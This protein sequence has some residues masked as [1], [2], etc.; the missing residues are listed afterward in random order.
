M[1]VLEVLAVGCIRAYQWVVRPVLPMACRFWPSCSDYALEAVRR[2]GVARGGILA[3]WRLLRCHPWGGSG[4]DP[5]PA[6]FRP[7]GQH[8]CRDVHDHI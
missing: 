1:K 4:L 2:H 7:W 5:V 6:H 8:R 3:V